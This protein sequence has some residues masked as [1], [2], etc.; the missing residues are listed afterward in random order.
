MTYF[1]PMS[2]SIPPENVRKP[3]AKIFGENGFIKGGQST[4]HCY[5]TIINMFFSA[6][7]LNKYIYGKEKLVQIN[8]NKLRATREIFLAVSRVDFGKV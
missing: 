1:S 7:I 5:S 8:I 2:V 4:D 6:V 3:L